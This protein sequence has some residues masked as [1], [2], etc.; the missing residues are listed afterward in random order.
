M[1][2][3]MIAFWEMSESDLKTF[4]IVLGTV[5]ALALIVAVILAVRIVKG[6]KGKVAVSK[7]DKVQT[8]SEYLEEMEMRGEFMV[9]ARNV[10]Y[11]VGVEGQIAA[12]KYL[13]ENTIDSEPDFNV[14][15]NGLVKEFH[16]G[17]TVYLAAGDTICGV[18]TS[19]MIKRV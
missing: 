10:I 3:S 1:F 7:E 16:S 17:D 8:A 13:L 2:K 18:S 19:I 5:C 12:G 15:F 6:N 9:L 11:S 14:R 4:V